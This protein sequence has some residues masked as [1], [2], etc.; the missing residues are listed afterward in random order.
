MKKAII[1]CLF[2]VALSM[3]Q[4]Q[5]VAVLPTMADPEAKLTARELDILTEKLRG[6]ASDVLPLSDFV[7]LKQDF[8][9]E[10]LGDEDFFKACKEGVCVGDLIA[11]VQADFGARC[12]VFSVSGKLWL[13]FELYGTLKGEDEAGTIS[14]FSG[15]AKDLKAMELL[16]EKKV[17]AAFKKI[18]TEIAPPVQVPTQYAANS[19]FVEIVTEPAG[20]ALS[21]NG[22]PLRD[23]PKTP[24]K[25][26]LY[27]N[28]VKLSAMLDEH[29]TA[30]TNLTITQPNQLVKINLR[31]TTYSVD[32]A[33]DPSGVNLVFGGGLTCSKTPCRMN[34]KKGNVQI[35][36]SKKFYETA[37]TTVFISKDN[38]LFNIKLNP[39][40]GV[41]NITP[42]Y[43]INGIGENENWN[44][45]IDGMYGKSFSIGKINFSP[46]NYSGELSH[47]CYEGIRIDSVKIEKGGSTDFNM[48][49]HLILKQ[50]T[51]V[52]KAKRKGRNISKPVFVNGEQVGE[53]P[54]DGSIPLCSDIYISEGGG[55]RYPINVNLERNK[56][57]EYTYRESTMVSH[58]IGAVLDAAGVVFLIQG[59]VAWSDRDKYHDD[60]VNLKGGGSPV[61]NAWK[62]VEDAHSKGNV[63][64]IIGGAALASGIGVHIWF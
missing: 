16:I 18:L 55:Q 7:L 11:K 12:E 48:S 51:L 26:A 6:Y 63:F 10:K 2:A 49:K 32:F 30:D 58:L 25:I 41:L 31:Q 1:I 17:P 33:S 59:M 54:F 3:A 13:K 62:K 64:L 23:C 40:Y 35:K 38:R 53:T 19:Y 52:L 44:L 42:A 43:Y 56:P 36:A 28:K 39:N 4:R 47:S 29:E 9:K 34:F 8:V 24:C 60:Y 15:E 5:R 57:V 21:L 37:D 50:G 14:T 20:A 22:V 61:S 27:E 46:G 45:T